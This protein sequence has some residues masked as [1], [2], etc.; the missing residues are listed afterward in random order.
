MPHSLR[1]ID[2]LCPDVVNVWFTH[3]SGRRYDKQEDG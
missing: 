3:R 2:P 1:P